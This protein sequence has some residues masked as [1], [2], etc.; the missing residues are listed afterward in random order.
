MTAPSK[1]P[2]CRL[3]L[4]QSWAGANDANAKCPYC[5][6]PLAG[7]PATGQG[8]MSGAVSPAP[9]QPAPKAAAKTILW[10]VGAP[11][12]GMPAK[13]APLPDNQPAP[14]A[15]NWPPSPVAAPVPNDN[16]IGVLATAN[17]DAVR[18]SGFAAQAAPALAPDAGGFDVN[19]EE[20]V[21]TGAGQPTKSSQPA[22]TVMFESGMGQI[23]DSLG[24]MEKLAPEPEP[25]PVESQA[26]AVEEE[27]A[28]QEEETVRRSTP[29]RNKFKGKPTQRKGA[30]AW[31]GTQTRR[32]SQDEEESAP[33]KSSS[34][35]GL[36]VFLALLLVGA[37]VIGVV[38]LRG[39]KKVDVDKPA[40][41]VEKPAAEPAPAAQ[42][43]PTPNDEPSGLAAKPT[44]EPPKPPPA[45]EPVRPAA[46]EKPAHAEKPVAEKPAHAEKP[47][48]EKPA[49]AEKPVAAEPKAA[50][51]K[52]SEEDYKRANE[53]YER[54]NAKLFQG[55][56]A[57][58][59]TDFNE[60]LKLNPKD[61]AAHRGL[62]LAY[63]Q[64]GKSAEAVK[65]LKT[66]LKESPK[67]ADRAL[68]EKRI[69]QLHGQ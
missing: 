1:C 29:T 52:P 22:A 45:D 31:S 38:L 3:S 8:T 65:Q 68:I 47:A 49:H 24:K 18:P 23:D 34:K 26:P 32:A 48:A 61:P 28:P 11:I 41:V 12:P 54:G 21:N 64:S 27:R 62:G 9:A 10:G 30:K 40:P 69:E 57:G 20:P 58:A 63:A 36:I 6:K 4:P 2:N 7:Q 16:D 56:T 13:T 53:A 19:V 42:P 46:V 5:G 51:G 17:R 67:D 14:A 50:A 25:A 43:E 55:N 60:A 33:K 15:A 44:F 37:A 59:I 66:Y 39:K 35:V